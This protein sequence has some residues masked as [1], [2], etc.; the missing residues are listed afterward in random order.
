MTDRIH[1]LQV[2]LAKDIREDDAEDLVKLL[3]LIRNVVG[4]KRNVADSVSHMA[5]E[6][7]K[8][9]LKEKLFDIVK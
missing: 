3:M 7:A 8:M 9:E 5:E 1:S 4:V 6:R 2:I